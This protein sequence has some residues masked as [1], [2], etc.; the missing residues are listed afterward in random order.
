MVQTAVEGK[1]KA[2]ERGPEPWKMHRCSI[3]HPQTGEVLDDGLAVFFKGPR[4]FTTEDVLELHVHSGRAI[5]SSV[6][7]AISFFPFCRPAER[8]EFTR[9]AFEGGRLDLTQVEGLRDLIDAETESQRRLALRSAG[10]A[11]RAR[12][13]T[14][15]N[16]VIQCLALVEALIDF[17][18]GEDIEEGVYDQGEIMRSGI[19]LAIF[20]PPN[21]GK[22]TLLNFLAQREAAIVTPIP[23]T[24]RDV[25]ELSLDIGGLP[26]IVAD[27]AGLRKT[28]DVVEKIGSSDVSLCVLSAPEALTGSAISGFSLDIPST[29]VPLLKDDTFI[30]LNKTDLLPPGTSPPNL[31][32]HEMWSVS[33]GTG[34]G[35]Q[36]FMDRFGKALKKRYLLQEG[37]FDGDE[38]LI[39][40]SRHRTHLESSLQFLD[41]FLTTA[42]EDIV[43]GAEELRYAAQAIGKISGLIDVEDILDASGFHSFPP[44]YPLLHIDAVNTA[45]SNSRRTSDVDPVLYVQGLNL[46]NPSACCHVKRGELRYLCPVSGDVDPLYAFAFLQTFVDILHEYFGQMSSETLKDNFDI[47]YQLLEETLDSGGHPLTTSP[48][49]LRDIVLPPSLLNKV[50]S[51]AG[52]SGLASSSA[53]SHPFASPIPWRKAGVRYNNNEIYFDVVET[54][55][56]IVNKNGTPAVSTV[57]GRVDSNCKLSGTPDL[58]LSFSNAQSLH[59][60]SFHPCVRLQRWSRDKVLSFVPPDG[61]FKL[62]DYRYAP[63]T[64]SAVAQT[65]IP[66]VFRP[67]IQIDEHGGTI[68]VTLSSRLSTRTMENMFV[69]LYLGEG[70]SGASCIA[71]HNASWSY[72]PKT[73]TLVWEIKQVMPSASYNLR[74]TF[75]STA[76]HPRPSR[77]FRIRFKILQHNFSAIK[78]EQ[79]KL[80]GEVYKP[81]KGMRGNSLGN[82]EWR[83]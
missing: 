15:R 17:G 4:S 42:P 26:V 31:V 71:S 2:R 66:I 21:A 62:M 16:E 72:S 70:A 23:G 80:T 19:R 56:A 64:A 65:S 30:L 47:V 14:L 3:G 78:I 12:L 41:A 83:W 9:R 69:E 36:L 61:K 39:T 82:I 79:L 67:T 38:A 53:T 35:T 32:S 28:D 81:Y 25:L 37:G 46:E 44:A 34:Q 5:I 20:G 40:H 49:A 1:G 13:E 11:T 24:T 43:F 45:L 76:E 8:G 10:G 48:N 60:C 57:W 75:S 68:D 73:Q 6:L 58:L 29:I 54:L 59:D 63:A 52:V 55:E 33:L 51:V 27:T 50:L 77:A 18:E 22:S 74:G 7:N